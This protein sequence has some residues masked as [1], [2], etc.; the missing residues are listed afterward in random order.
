MRDAIL[1]LILVVGTLRA[2]RHPYIGILVWTWVSIMNPHRESWH[3]STFPV[4]AMVGGATLIGMFLTRDKRQFFMTTPAVILLLFTLWMCIAYQ[5][6]FYPE[7]SV[8]M[9]VRVLKINF[10]IF[11]VM[12][13]LYTRRHIVALVW[14]L[15]GS[16]GY[17][18]VKGGAFTIATGGSYRVWGPSDSFIEGNNEVALALIMSIPLMY[19]LRSL[20]THAWIRHAFLAAMMLTAAAALGSQSRGALL[21]IV[22]MVGLFWLRLDSSGARGGPR[23]QKAMFGLLIIVG[24]IALAAFMPESWHSRMDSIGDYKQDASAQGRINAWHMA[25]NL[26]SRNFFGGGFEIYNKATFMAY[27]PDQNDV[28]AAHSIYFQVLGEH[29]FVGL[30]LF[31]LIWLFTWRWAGWLRK[32]ARFNAQT[33][34][35]AVLGAMV[36]ASLAGYIVGGAFLSLA[37]FDLPYNLMVLVIVTR[38]WVEH[39]QAGDDF[40]AEPLAAKSKRV[41]AGKNDRSDAKA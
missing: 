13:L 9:L 26:A 19:F 41:R 18:G 24:G 15:V 37:Y 21:A 30:L 22:T 38:R 39:Y 5:F 3:L 14:V 7:E 40:D 2:L 35:A 11:V 1:A 4:A 31:L 12:I 33:E 6:S 23:S 34:W 8:K 20:Y 10:M 16:L 28:H 32:N 17:Y 36:Q 25:W 27:A 29:G